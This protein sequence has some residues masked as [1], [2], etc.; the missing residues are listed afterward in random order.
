MAKYEPSHLK[1]MNTKIVF[2]EFRNSDNES[3]FVN[4]LARTTKISVPTVMKIVDFLTEKELIKEQE[5]TTTKVGRK[6]NL[7]KLNN[8]KFFSIGIVYE[9]D[10]LIMGIVDLAG[11]VQNFIQIRCGQHFEQS[12]F[13][14]IDKLLEMC[15]KDVDDLIGIGIGIP[16]I[17]DS[18]T[19]NITAA[20]LI[21]ID[22]PRYF[23]DV[24]D[25]ISKK[26]NA[27]VVVDND[28]N[29]QA[30]GE[31]ASFKPSK[32]EDLIFI[33]L[34]TGLG[35]GAVIDGKVRRGSNNICGEIGYMMFEYSDEESKSGWLEEQIN[36]NALKDKFDISE[37][38]DAGNQ[39]KAIEYVSRYMALLVNNLIFC[40]DTSKIV[41][42]GYVLDLLGDDLLAAI[43]AKLDRI[44]YKPIKIEKKNVVMP[45][46]LGG[47]LLASNSWLEEVFKQ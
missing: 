38:S 9:G 10:Y 3:L 13:K 24:I 42:D 28:L 41:L 4:E 34:G 25:R 2:Q 21:G 22:K 12:L 14:N 16:C 15:R 7:F 27:K 26:Y 44:C 29:I 47:A 35:A 46:L 20:P 17:F 18:K 23:G 43:Q 31:Y 6:P 1:N 30:F 19:R 32:K 11:K 8:E 37:T 45:G 39:E 5:C 33:S 36:L 40:Y